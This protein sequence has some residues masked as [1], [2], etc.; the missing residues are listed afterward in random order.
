MTPPKWLIYQAVSHIRELLLTEHGGP[1]GIRD[2]SLL[3]SALNQPIDKFAYEPNCGMH[4]LA[5]AYA[6]G[7]ARNH[8]FIDGNKRTAFVCA[9]L[10]LEMNGYTVDAPEAD[11]VIIMEALAAGTLDEAQLSEWF[12]SNSSISE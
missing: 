9:T 2:E 8:P 6:F 7:I 3:Q 5:A 10:F 4:D 12:R 11:T 1:P